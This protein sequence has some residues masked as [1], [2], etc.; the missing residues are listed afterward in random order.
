MAKHL[1]YGKKG[2]EIAHSYLL[3]LNYQIIAVNWRY[4]HL[5]VDIIAKDGDTLVFVEVK[6]RSTTDYGYPASFVDTKKQRHLINAAEAY[7]ELSA[8]EGEIRFDIVAI[9]WDKSPI[10]EL[11]K[12]AFWSS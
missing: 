3:G 9:Q 6:T 8:Y 2:E 1:K 11:I 7:L 4:K 12:D 10:I 5:E